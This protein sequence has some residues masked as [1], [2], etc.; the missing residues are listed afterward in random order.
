MSPETTF[1]DKAN[2]NWLPQQR[3]MTDR[4]TNFRL[5]IYSHSS[6]NPEILAKIGPLRFEII[7]LT[8]IVNNEYKIRNRNRT[9]SL[10]YLL[11]AAGQAKLQY[12]V[13][14]LPSSVRMML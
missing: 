12:C 4:K 5:T 6:T 9:C 14:M 3:P 10:L 7:G 8:G 1:V 11:S 13:A 2:K